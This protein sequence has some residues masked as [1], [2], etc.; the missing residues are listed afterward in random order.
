MS[1]G[2]KSFKWIQKHVSQLCT[3]I[4]KGPQ[5]TLYEL[6]CLYV[7]VDFSVCLLTTKK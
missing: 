2:I 3:F 1:K 6:H 4:L 5:T 7:C